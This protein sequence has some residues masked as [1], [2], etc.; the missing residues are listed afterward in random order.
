MLIALAVIEIE[1]N[2]SLF[3]RSLLTSF[4]E[5]DIH[6]NKMRVPLRCP[7]PP[8]SSLQVARQFHCTPRVLARRDVPKKMPLPRDLVDFDMEEDFPEF[9]GNDIPSGAHIALHQQRQL[10]YYMRLIENEMPK[11]VG[12]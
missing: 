8:F 10:A 9:S 11:L 7:R 1:T 6:S 12:K 2:L 3:G 5:V 4:L